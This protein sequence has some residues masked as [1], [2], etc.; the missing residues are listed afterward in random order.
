MLWQYCLAWRGLAPIAKYVAND[1]IALLAPSFGISC[2][3]HA[4]AGSL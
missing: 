2:P 1:A 3:A 4:P